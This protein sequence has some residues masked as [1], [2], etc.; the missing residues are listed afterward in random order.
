MHV[1]R[2]VLRRQLRVL[3][4]DVLLGKMYL[5][6]RA[7][8][9]ASGCLQHERGMLLGDLR[10]R[11]VRVGDAGRLHRARGAVRRRHAVL[12]GVVQQRAVRS[13]S[14]ALPCEWL[15]LRG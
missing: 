4:G 12:F 2:R 10:A 8:M 3:L 9:L 1:R 13:G 6:Q 5:W 11:V 14:R 15:G 7:R